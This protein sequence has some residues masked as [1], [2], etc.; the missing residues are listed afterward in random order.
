MGVNRYLHFLI[1]F[2]PYTK[3]QPSAMGTCPSIFLYFKILPEFKSCLEVGNVSTASAE[4]R[5]G[6]QESTFTGR[7][8]GGGGGGPVRQLVQPPC[9]RPMRAEYARYAQIWSSEH[10]VTQGGLVGASS[11]LGGAGVPA[12]QLGIGLL[13]TAL[14]EM[15]S[16]CCCCCLCLLHWK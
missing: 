9:S 6:L 11:L 14:N 8:G 10:P 13:L 5:L 1:H 2:L 7:G 16:G 4:F 15:L 12:C 3:L